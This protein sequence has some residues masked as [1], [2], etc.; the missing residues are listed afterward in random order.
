MNKDEIRKLLKK[1]EK[2]AKDLAGQAGNLIKEVEKDAS[3][4]TKASK[5]KVE[6]FTLESER[7]ALI[8]EL[9]EK[10]YPMLRKEKVD[11]KKVKDLV[12]EIQDIENQIRGKKSSLTKMKN[13]RK[14]RKS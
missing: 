1:T 2:K 14:E 6:Q 9:G 12:E 5:V 3:Y 11:M 10:V 8:T 4:G 7:K 13:K